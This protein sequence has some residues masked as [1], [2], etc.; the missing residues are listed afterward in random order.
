MDR[1]RAWVTVKPGEVVMEE[2]DIPEI[3]ED[4][5]LLKVEACG[6]CGTDK[7]V[8]SG[9]SPGALFPLITG[10][11]F[12]GTIVEMG[13]KASDSMAVFGGALKVGDRVS[14]VPSSMPC[15][16]CYYCLH[17]P[18]RPALC[19]GRSV[20]GYVPVYK[21]PGIWGGFSEYVYLHPRSYVF[22][23]PKGMV[24]KRAVLA[25]PLAVALR[26]VERAYSPG[27]PFMSH[28][29][30]VG[31]SAM[32]LG[33]GPIGVM[34][35][36]ALR[37]SGAGLIIAQDLFATKLNLAKRMGADIVIDGNLPLEERLKQVRELTDG[38]G[39]DVVIEAAGVPDAFR[40]ALEFARRGGKMI[41]V[42]HYVDTGGSDVHPFA[43]CYKDLDI[44][45]SWAYPALIFRDAISLLENTSLPVAEVVTHVLPLGDFPKGLDISASEEAGKVVIAPG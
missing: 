40:E 12:I 10:H 27:E 45:G 38:V 5:A 16:H 41:E 31:R 44:H 32:V 33:A 1:C 37:Y 34:V 3:P 35:I 4:S 8:Y 29:Y 43:I 42:G 23:L 39:P 15:G 20:Y 6:I 11:E 21:S 30:G 18:H 26:A 9:R 13:N 14:I 17:M 22:K 28:G 36:A 24:M 25:E 19:T 7:H 2:F